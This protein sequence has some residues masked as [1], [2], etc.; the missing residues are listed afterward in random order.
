MLFFEPASP[1]SELYPAAAH[2]VDLRG[3]N[4][5]LAGMPERNGAD[6]SADTHSFCLTREPGQSRPGVEWSG[7]AA[8]LLSH[9][10]VVVR[11][12]EALEAKGLGPLGES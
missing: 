11:R 7:K 10:Y 3:L 4:G 9:L 6:K 5:E 8:D 2:V 12:E 1:E